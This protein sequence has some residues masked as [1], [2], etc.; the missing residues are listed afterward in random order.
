MNT[1]TYTFY[2][3][4]ETST[5]E[6]DNS[7]DLTTLF[8][9]NFRSYKFVLKAAG[10]ATKVDSWI[11][12]IIKICPEYALLIAGEHRGH[13]ESYHSENYPPLTV[14]IQLDDQKIPLWT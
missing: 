8:T 3:H 10:Q 11:D 5:P 1:Y 6:L 9:S 2:L 7:A 14:N 4:T 13:L 12:Y